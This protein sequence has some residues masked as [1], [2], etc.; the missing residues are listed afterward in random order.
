[1]KT[2]A[3]LL[4]LCVGLSCCGQTGALYL[5]ESRQAALDQTPSTQP[6]SERAVPEATLPDESL[7]DNSTPN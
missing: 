5:P 6:E 7:N 3:A 1:M 2:L 4:L